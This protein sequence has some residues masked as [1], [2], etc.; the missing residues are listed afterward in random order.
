MKPDPNGRPTILEAL[1]RHAIRLDLRSVPAA[2]LDRTKL[3]ILDLLGCLLAGAGSDPA[4]QVADLVVRQGGR[5]EA[6]VV[7]RVGR[8]PAESAALA[9]GVAAHALELDDAHRFATGLHPGA[10]VIPAALAVAEAEEAS[11]ED[12]LAAVL[13]GYDVAGRIGTALNP[14]HRYRGFHST[15]TIGPFGAA[16]AA[17]RLLGLDA[18]RATAALSLVASQGSGI[19][20][21]LADSSTVKL[22]HA[23]WA[24]QKGVQAALLARAGLAG[25]PSAL[26]GREGFARAYAQEFRPEEVTRELGSSFEVDRVYFKLHAACGHAFSAIDAALA[27]RAE[28]GGS[29]EGDFGQ[30]LATA[31]RS[32]RV[33]SYRAAAVLANREPST[34][35]QAR[36]SI[37]HCV[38]AALVLGSAGLEAF[39]SEARRSPAIR[40]ISGV[41]EVVEDPAITATFPAR[42][43]AVVEMVLRDG[44]R[45][46]KAVDYPRG[47]P[48]N[49]VSEGE[50]V[51]KFHLLAASRLD[52]ARRQSLIERVRTLEKLPSVAGLA[53][54]G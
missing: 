54:G 23:G 27:L 11:G 21:F 35:A 44:R 16:A 34:E 17:S 41:T 53:T 32:V 14:S 46:E 19:F 2:T 49:P 7:G 40:R 18:H 1:A 26:E 15:G 38:A 13:V 29:E 12:L 33:S 45:L 3:C 28:L 31:I 5:A 48:E 8:V 51:G 50:L 22:L 20:E 30:K 43:T 36:F 6:T 39:G 25:P 10:T 4:R 47:T 42:R 24:A 9:N 37:P 52:P